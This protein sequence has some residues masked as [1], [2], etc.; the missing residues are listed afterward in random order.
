M[1]L[2]FVDDF[3]S[4]TFPIQ[5][6]FFTGS[7]FGSFWYHAIGFWLSFVNGK[8]ISNGFDKSTENVKSEIVIFAFNRIL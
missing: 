2:K 4:E 5:S 7:I 1:L 3:P 6:P 8:E